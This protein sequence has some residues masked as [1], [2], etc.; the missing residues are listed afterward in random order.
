MTLIYI[1]RNEINHDNLLLSTC[2]RV[3]LIQNLKRAQRGKII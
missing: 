2:V 1:I 3:T